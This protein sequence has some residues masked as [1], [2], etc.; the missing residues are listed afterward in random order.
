MTIVCVFKLRVKELLT[1]GLPIVFYDASSSQAVYNEL[2]RLLCTSSYP[3][4]FIVLDIYEN[5]QT[6]VSNQISSLQTVLIL[7]EEGPRRVATD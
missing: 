6:P 1:R 7:V 3:E 2:D 5:S 4:S